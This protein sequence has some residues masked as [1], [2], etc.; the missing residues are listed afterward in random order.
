VL[1]GQDLATVFDQLG[2]GSDFTSQSPLRYTHR[3][4]GQRQIYFVANPE[5]QA[6]ATL[7]TFRVGGRA[8]AFWWPDSGRIERPAVYEQDEG[9]VSLPIVLGPHGS[10]FVVFGDQ[11]AAAGRIVSVARGGETILDATATAIRP[12]EIQ[13]AAAAEVAGNFT[14]AV[15]VRPTS[16]TA[17]VAESNTGVHGLRGPRNDV[18]TAT[19]GADLGGEGHAGCGLAVGRNGICVFEHSHNYFAPPLVYEAPIADW[20]HVAVVYRDNQPHLYRNGQLVHTGLKSRHRVHPGSTAPSFGGQRGAVQQIA[21]ALGDRELRAL[22][23]SMPR[24]GALL[25]AQTVQLTVAD[26]GDIVG[27]FQ[28]AGTY[29]LTAAGGKVRIVEVTGVP[30]P[31]EVGGPWQ[32][33]FQAPG[34]TSQKTS[35]D[36][37]CDWTAHADERIRYFSGQATYRTVF[38]IPDAWKGSDVRL[39]LGQVHG[40]A[41]VRLNGQRLETLWM[42]PWHIDITPALRQGENVL[43]VDIVNSWHNRL[44]GDAGLP[45][46]KRQTILLRQTVTENQPLQPAGLLGPVT[47]TTAETREF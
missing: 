33:M 19:H 45:L 32:V 22:A 24:P 46:E 28:Q 18:I 11:P 7:A 47:I 26:D 36:A 29:R 2:I 6:V 17:I 3:S 31:V 12:A 16:D 43:E 41:T 30:A 39:D 9:I 1:W 14:L 42:Q 13:P 8:P 23:Q 20:T 21:R 10:V 38:T 27:R 40:L 4:A 44:A 25:P 5:P 37:L 35:F 15:W 34:G